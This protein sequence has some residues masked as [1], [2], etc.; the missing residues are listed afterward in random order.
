NVWIHIP[1]GYGKTMFS[2]KLNWR[3]HTEPD[4]NML[5]RQIYWP[6]GKTLG[7]SS[8]INGLIYIRG[9]KQDYDHWEAQGNPGWGWDACLPYFRKLEDNDLGASETRGTGGPLSTSSIPVRHELVEA[10]I[11]AAGQHGL[12]RLD[13]FNTGDQEGVGYYQLTTRRGKRCSTAVAYLRPAKKRSNL[14]IITNA[15]VSRV[16]FEGTRATGVKYRQ[17]GQCKTLH[18]N[19][20]VILCA[21]AL[22]S[23]QLLQLSGVGAAGHLREFGIPVV[24]NLPGVG[25]NLQDHLQLR[26]IYEVSKPITNNDQL[27]SLWGQMKM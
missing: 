22:Q 2:K 11:D 20:E 8:S 5:G 27:R 24:N 25:E 26:L 10:F 6:R 16:C 19:K 13:D 1:I 12:K 9:Q 17:G 18:A 3:Y 7:G 21:G 14:R 23:P 15:H 4:P